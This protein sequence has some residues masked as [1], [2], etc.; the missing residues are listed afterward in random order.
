MILYNEEQDQMQ[1]KAKNR[2]PILFL[3]RG[4]VHILRDF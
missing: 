1:Q 3:S 2:E 4:Y